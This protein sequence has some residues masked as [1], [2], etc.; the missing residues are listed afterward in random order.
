MALLSLE[1]GKVAYALDF[2]LYGAAAVVLGAST[3]A[4]APHDRLVTIT[5]TACVVSG[6][7][8]WT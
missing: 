8:S 4:S 2:A 7:A 5:A 1:H 3:V 6:L